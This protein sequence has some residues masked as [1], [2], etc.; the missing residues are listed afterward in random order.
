MPERIEVSFTRRGSEF[1]FRIHDQ[2]SDWGIAPPREMVIAALVMPGDDVL[3]YEVK[4]MYCPAISRN[5][6]FLASGRYQFDHYD[7]PMYGGHAKTVRNIRR[8]ITAL[9]NA[10]RRDGHE[11]VIREYKEAEHV[12]EDGD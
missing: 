8:A 2:P 7:A 11:F 1:V 10:A 5:D 12:S 3:L 9:F 4:V 6:C